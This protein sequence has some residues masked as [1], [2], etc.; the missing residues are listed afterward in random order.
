VCSAVLLSMLACGHGVEPM[1]TPHRAAMSEPCDMPPPAPMLPILMPT[2]PSRCLPLAERR[3]GVSLAVRL[4]PSGEVVGVSEAVTT[5]LTTNAHGEVV[6]K[7]SPDQAV[8]DCIGREMK[9]WRFM[10]VATCGENYAY[11]DV[12]EPRDGH[13]ARAVDARS[14]CGA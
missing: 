7:Y 1:P 14:T 4:S 6:P 3:N 10:T 13:R 5:C 9:A 8:L 2:D 11:V 12:A